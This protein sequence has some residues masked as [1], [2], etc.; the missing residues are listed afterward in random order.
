MVGQTINSSTTT[1][2]NKLNLDENVI[3]GLVD[4]CIL[5]CNNF[6]GKIQLKT[7]TESGLHNLFLLFWHCMAV[8]IDRI[9]DSEMVY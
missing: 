5:N 1:K 6:Y 2:E 3:L 7:K 8:T 4:F 9:L